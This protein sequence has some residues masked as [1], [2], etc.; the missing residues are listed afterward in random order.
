MDRAWGW[1][2]GGM[3]ADGHVS[4]WNHVLC[5][6]PLREGAQ[7]YWGRKNTKFPT[8]VQSSRPLGDILEEVLSGHQAASAEA[9]L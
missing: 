3:L 9:H 5:W 1:V 2:E 4:F 7:D 8:A 6:E